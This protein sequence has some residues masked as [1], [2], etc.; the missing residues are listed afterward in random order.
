ATGQSSY[1][2]A[3]EVAGDGI[4]Q[5]CDAV[6]DC[7]QDN[8]GDTYHGTVVTGT[9]LDCTGT[10]ESSTSTDCD[11][12]TGA[13]DIYLGATEVV[14]DGIDQNCDNVDDCYQDLDDD[15]FGSTTTVTASTLDCD[16]EAN[17]SNVSTD[18]ND[19]DD[20]T[21]QSSY[22]GAPEVAGDGIDQ[23]CDNVD[24]CYQDLDDDNF[25]ST[26]TVTASTLDC[27]SEAN[28]SNVSTDCNDTDDA[29]GQSSYPGAP[30]VAGDGIDQNCDAV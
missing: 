18:C 28:V 23:N 6:D 13:I 26:T 15:N 24:D 10:G 25:G 4:D 20:A 12:T 1:P 27:D 2:G 30:E 8:D 14:G 7:Y 5:N 16:T 22:P 21:G 3:P 9:T 29:T 11:D 17:V 19:T